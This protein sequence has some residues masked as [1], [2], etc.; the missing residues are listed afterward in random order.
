[1]SR[2]TLG[3][4]TGYEDLLTE[5]RLELQIHQKEKWEVVELFLSARRRMFV[6]RVGCPGAMGRVSGAPHRVQTR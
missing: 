5:Q 2:C 6:H 4:W 1:M 3:S